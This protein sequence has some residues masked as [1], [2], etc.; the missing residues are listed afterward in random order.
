MKHSQTFPTRDLALAY[1]TGLR[2]LT[3]YAPDRE[4]WFR[5][6]APDGVHAGRWTVHMF[7][8]PRDGRRRIGH[9][10]DA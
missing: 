6:E 2:L 1:L 9:R 3:P 8:A 5:T 10:L 7:S 4:I